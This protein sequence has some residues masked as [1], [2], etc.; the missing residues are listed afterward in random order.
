MIIKQLLSSMNLY[1]GKTV[2]IS[3]MVAKAKQRAK[4][5]LRQE[6]RCW[7]MH[8]FHFCLR[9]CIYST[10]RDII[11]SI[12]QYFHEQLKIRDHSSIGI[13]PLIF[14]K[15]LIGKILS[16]FKYCAKIWKCKSIYILTTLHFSQIKLMLLFKISEA[17]NKVM[18]ACRIFKFLLHCL[19]IFSVC[20]WMHPC[21]SMTME[22]EDDL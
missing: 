12:H 4:K 13:F 7:S 16:H 22:S 18:Q 10:R 2:I 15:H 11:Y 1:I 6:Y 19:V 14:Q 20:M 3:C 17:Y 21:Y 9:T 5:E 8:F